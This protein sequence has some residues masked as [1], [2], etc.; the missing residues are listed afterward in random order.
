AEA[1]KRTPRLRIT[2]VDAAARGALNYIGIAV[3]KFRAVVMFVP[4]DHRERTFTQ[5][6][7]EYRP[8]VH[9]ARVI[10]HRLVKKEKGVARILRGS[11]IS[12]RPLHHLLPRRPTPVDTL[13]LRVVNQEMATL[14]VK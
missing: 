2:Q 7:F 10:P 14:V 12:F 1:V 4:R 11:E 8:V 3:A 9:E 5:R 6:I 13:L